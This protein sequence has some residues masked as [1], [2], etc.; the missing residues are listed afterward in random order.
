MTSHVGDG[1]I[2]QRLASGSGAPIVVAD[3]QAFSTAPRL[4]EQLAER[5]TDRPIYQADPV[6]VLSREQSYLTLPELATAC[7][8]ELDSFL[9][10][11][12]HVLVIGHCSAAGL[13]LRISTLLKNTETIL[14]EPTWP[15]SAHVGIRFADFQRNVGAT[16]LPCPDLDDEPLV[17]LAQ[18]ERALHDGLAKAAAAQGVSATSDV[19]GDLLA[20]Y[21]GWL[22]FLLACRND[23]PVT[24]PA[25]AGVVRVLTQGRD[26]AEFSRVNPAVRRVIELPVSAATVTPEL[27]DYVVTELA[28]AL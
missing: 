7:S 19:F 5:I 10:A 16:E 25:G 20:W 9:S 23:V 21:R 28:R 11:Q 26:E 6:G 8:G 27:T 14:V 4:S 18:M 2:M 12:D 3:F 24:V 22:A 15:D 1:L 17:V 13:A